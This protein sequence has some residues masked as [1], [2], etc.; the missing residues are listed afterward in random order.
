MEAHALRLGVVVVVV[1]CA[2][3]DRVRTWGGPQLRVRRTHGPLLLL[4]LPPAASIPRLPVN[5]D[6]RPCMV[7]ESM[8]APRL[9]RGAA[10]GVMEGL[11]WSGAVL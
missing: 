5:R 8:C 11:R 9:G 4:L 3:A 2:P 1:A 6:V 7:W 10:S